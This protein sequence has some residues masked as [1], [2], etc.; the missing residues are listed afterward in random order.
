MRRIL[1]FSNCIQSNTNNKASGSW[2]YSMARLLVGTPDIHL[3]N[4]TNAI[5]KKKEIQHVRISE[6]F[7]EYILPNWPIDKDGCPSLENCRKISELCTKINPDLVHVWGIEK[8]FARIVSKLDL[9]VPVLLEMQGIRKPCA[10]VF[11]GE[12]SLSDIW[13]CMG[14]REFLFPFHKSIYAQ[15][16]QM[17]RR[18]VKDE[19][20]LKRFQYISTQSR[21][22]RNHIRPLVPDAK[23]FKTGMSLRSEFWNSKQWQYPKNGVK[24]FYCSASAPI[25][26]KSIQTAIKALSIV[27]KSYP[28]TKLYIIGDFRTSNWLRQTG[29]LT[30]LL[31]LIKKCNLQ[32]NVVFTGPLNASEI[33]Q[34]MHHCVGMVQ[35]SY[36][37]SYSLAVAEAQAVG[38]PSIIS[39]AGAMPELAIDRETGL[40]FS[41]GD[42][43]SCAACMMEIIMN[44]SLA[45]SISEK[46]YMLAR[47]RND[48]ACVLACQLNIYNEILDG[49]N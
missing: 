25:S 12:M 9:S 48:D 2:L 37:E 46:S 1:W 38:I 28:D 4:I 44:E 39:Y 34:I 17:Y 13:H 6:N 43:C 36:V 7:E 5:T 21:W 29:Y 23:I 8:Y 30:F 3:V 24:D 11:Y 33:I 16:K 35:T 40:F 10:E 47:K 42:Y 49:R 41:P 19:D 31:N 27:V 14:F 20:I 26:Y 18:G 22:V 45:M 32:K 15:K